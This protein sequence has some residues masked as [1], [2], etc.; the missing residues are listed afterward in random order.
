MPA[1]AVA[2]AGIG[3]AVG[4]VLA[5]NAQKSAAADQAKAYLAAAKLQAA[6]YGKAGDISAKAALQA[7]RLLAPAART[8]AGQQVGAANTAIGTQQTAGTNA[9]GAEQSALADVKTQMSPY[10][11]AGAGATYSLADLYGLPTPSN[12]N[13]G[14]PLSDSSLAAFRNSPDYEF[15]RQEGEKAVQQSAA[16]KGGLLTGGTEKDLTTFGQGLASQQFGNYFNRLLQLS[17]MGQSAAGTVSSADVNTG[18]DI[19]GIYQNTGRGVATTQLAA[20][21]AQARGT[22]GA[23]GARATGITSAAGAKAVGLT[24]ATS[25]YTQALEN[26]A[27]INAAGSAGAYNN[28]SGGVSDAFDNLALAKYMQGNMPTGAAK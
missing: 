24:G 15:A 22:L 20:G 1:W 4:G 28:I 7:S 3:S 16:A 14:Q 11:K 19:A 23:A 17:Q 10:T 8:A 13:G 26:A 27:N 21:D 18:A 2:V 6:G 25:A 5:G 9:I 12:P